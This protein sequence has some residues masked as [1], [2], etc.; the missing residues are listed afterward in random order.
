MSEEGHR[1]SLY[2]F[3]CCR[4]KSVSPSPIVSSLPPPYISLSSDLHSLNNRV[5]QVETAITQLSAIVA[6]IPSNFGQ[7]Q[8]QAKAIFAGSALSISH[9]IILLWINYL[10][11]DDA[12]CPSFHPHQSTPLDR[13]PEN[14]QGST[15]SLPPLNAYQFSPP[16]ASQVLL[17]NLPGGRYRTVFLDNVQQFFRLRPSFH[18]QPFRTRVEHLFASLDETTFNPLLRPKPSLGRGTTPQ[19]PSTASFFAA[20][21]ATFAL[22][23]LL[24]S[25]DDPDDDISVDP[26]RRAL[27]R[28]TGANVPKR[29]SP[30]YLHAL[31]AQALSVHEASAPIDIDYLLACILQVI[32]HLQGGDPFATPA[33]KNPGGV[34]L[35]MVIVVHL[36][37]SEFSN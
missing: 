27:L 32:F 33:F 19:T 24:G 15:H 10:G 30:A 11:L 5:L 7:P 3:T 22:G 34:L 37:W 28:Q 8:S 12:I 18:W 21:A 26:S 35:P 31:S 9:D 17:T 16:N 2:L 25:K 4:R 6:N 14:D 13:D 20:T 1:L 23:A 36:P 29:L